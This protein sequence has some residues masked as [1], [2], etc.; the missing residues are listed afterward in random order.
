MIAD[1]LVTDLGLEGRLFKCLRLD[2]LCEKNR[3]GGGLVGGPKAYVCISRSHT[4]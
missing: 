2:G 4:R 3:V 1:G